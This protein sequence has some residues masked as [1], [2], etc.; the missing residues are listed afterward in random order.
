MWTSLWMGTS[1]FSRLLVGRTKWVMFSEVFLLANYWNMNTYASWCDYTRVGSIGSVVR[2]SVGSLISTR[3][4]YVSLLW[5]IEDLDVLII[6][7]RL[8]W[9]SDIWR[10][11]VTP[12][13]PLFVE[14]HLPDIIRVVS[15]DCVDL[16]ETQTLLNKIVKLVPLVRLDSFLKCPRSSNGVAHRLATIDVCNDNF[17][18][19]FVENSSSSSK[20]GMLEFGLHK[21]K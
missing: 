17:V 14:S 18:F 7:H 20:E 16:Y 12:T 19:S 11:Y 5:A 3:R 1:L 6:I 8:S 10:D 15:G 13:P 2:D 9:F 4:R 21:P